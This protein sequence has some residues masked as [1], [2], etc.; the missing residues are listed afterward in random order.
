MEFNLKEIDDLTP[1]YRNKLE[2]ELSVQER[3][4][5]TAIC[6]YAK[7]GNITVKQAA[8]NARIVQ[9]NQV[10]TIMGRLV[11]KNFLS[12]VSKSTYAVSDKK[13][14]AHLLVRACGICRK[15]VIPKEYGIVVT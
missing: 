14:V 3:K 10:H 13:L 15:G 1:Y 7:D 6:R 8:T 12:K 11:K 4:V 2:G 9:L 5:M